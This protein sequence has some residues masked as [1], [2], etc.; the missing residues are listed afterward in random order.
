MR[1]DDVSFF[2][3]FLESS[4]TF[5]YFLHIDEANQNKNILSETIKS[6]FKA[7]G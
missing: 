3:S 5:R 2:E 1:H 4:Q 6:D 7:N